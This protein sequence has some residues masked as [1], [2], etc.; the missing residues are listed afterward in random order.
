MALAVL[1]LTLLLACA[2][3]P[4]PSS[5]R[6]TPPPEVSS[7]TS[8]PVLAAL[9]PEPTATPVGLGRQTNDPTAVVVF[10]PSAMGQ[11][12]TDLGSQFMLAAPDATGVSYRFDT[13]ATLLG[14]IQQGADADVIVSLDRSTIDTLQQASLLDGSPTTLVGDQ[15]AIVTSKANP[16]QVQTLKDLANSGVRFIVPAPTS[17]TTTAL[18]AAFDA[19]SRDPAYGA[20]FGARADRNVLA[21]DGD[22]H[23]VISRILAGEVTAGVVFASSVN[24]SSQAQ[25]QTI[26]FP[27]SISTL[28]EYTIGVLKNGTNLRGAQ[29]FVKYALS[30]PAQD[31]LSRYG[32][33]RLGSST[34][35]S[36]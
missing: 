8:P 34:N 36:R 11:A 35:A 22:D 10:A 15:L 7:P 23:L 31:I 20:D 26:V 19:A 33:R 13:P 28:S 3:P 24:P 6:V 5:P 16:Q 12:L 9:P 25:L 18:K 1:A 2:G 32:F 17:P 29:A 4:P 14:L 21:R 27:A 30:A